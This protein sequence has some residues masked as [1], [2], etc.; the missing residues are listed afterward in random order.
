[1]SVVLSNIF[2]LF[3]RKTRLNLLLRKKQNRFLE[4]K[5]LKF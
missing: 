2:S 4:L 3:K 1:M 5:K